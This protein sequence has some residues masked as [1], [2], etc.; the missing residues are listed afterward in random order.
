MK[1]RNFQPT[2]PSVDFPKNDE[3]VLAFWADKR[4]FKRSEET[5][6]GKQPFV[7]YDGPPGTNG[8]PHIGHI[9]QSSLKDV[10]P[11]FKTMQGYYVLRK[12]GWDTHGLPVELTSE[13][14]LGLKG[15]VDIEKFGVGKFIEHCR[16]TVLRFRSDWV[17]AITRLGRFVDFEDDYLTMSNDFIQSDWWVIRQAF[18]KG[19][20]Y[21]DYKI[22]PY[23]SR[24]GTGL[25]SHEVAQGYQDITD[26]TITAKFRLLKKPDT[27]ILAWTTTPWTLLGNVALAIN[28]ELEYCEVATTAQ[29]NERFILAKGTLEKN[30]KALGKDYQ[31]VR[32]FMGSELVG[33][34]YE[35]LWDFSK[36]PSSDTKAHIVIA[37]NY[38]TTDDGTGVVH[39]A[40]YGEDDFRLIKRNG[41]YQNQ[42]VGADGR[43]AARCGSY[44]GR[45][46][47]EEGLDV[48]IVKDLAARGLLFDKYRYE[49][50]YP[51]CW[52]CKSPLMYF[53]KSS[54]FL[55][56]TAIKD[57]MIAANNEINWQPPHTKEGRFGNWLE[58]NVDWAVSR[59]R[60]W[61]S[62]INVWASEK[63]PAKRI[64][65]ASVRELQELGAFFQ[66]SGK[67]IPSD[68]DLHIP[69]IDDVVF[70]GSDGDLYRRESGVLDCWFNAGAMP[71]G[72][73]GYPE[74]AGSKDIFKT[75][76]PADFICEAVDQTR[77]WFYTLLAVSTIVTGKSSFKNVICTDLILD[78]SGRK[79]SKSLGNV[80]A[81]YPL[82]EKFGADAVRWTFYDSNPWQTKRYSEELPKEA[83]RAVFIPIWN[84]YSFFVTYAL[85][86]K[87]TP[88]QRSEKTSTVE[89]DRWIL[90]SLRSAIE[91]V[92]SALEGYDIAT[93]A[94]AISDFI[95]HL[96]NWY[97]RRS[98]KRFW[99]SE[100]DQ[101]KRFAY[102]TLYDVL[103]TFSKL[104]AP[105]APFVAETIYQNL[106]RSFDDSAPESVHL[107]DWPKP[108]AFPREE[109]LEQEIGLIQEAAS[110]AR[111]LRTEHNLK[112]RQPLG[113]LI[114]SPADSAL[115]DAVRRHTESLV[116]EINIKEV[117]VS[118]RSADF[119]TLTIKPNW[120]ALGPRFGEKMK[121]VGAAIQKLSPEEV[122]AIAAG[123]SVTIAL[124]AESVALEPT[125]LLIEQ[126]AKEGMVARAGRGVTVA[127]TTELTKELILEGHAREVL[128]VIQRQRKAEGFEISDHINVSIWGDADLVAACTE[129]KGYLERECLAKSFQVAEGLPSGKETF[130]INGHAAC[131]ELRKIA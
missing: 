8:V 10:W 107:C 118:D 129:H 33:L 78:S 4:V 105:M 123:K 117:V 128:S 122:Q 130:D 58:N 35:P 18:D 74:K 3:S 114:V 94:K 63:D 103:V 13:A 32:T 6:A 112:V 38:V 60:Y 9:M 121:E 39:M 7:F 25:S 19:L 111:A 44:A 84:C 42:H 81:P 99:K 97:I 22:V 108:D 92:T 45:Y 87:W 69:T 96:S 73:F 79:M 77:G 30:A 83:L 29:P 20:L 71:W 70:K 67:P 85:L 104:I 89:L 23:C 124:G 51:H 115:I 48:D 53:A 131:L 110:L 11:R 66:S 40:L 17:K 125:D 43:I 1:E 27:S 86:D 106:V 14:E 116:E 28:A 49:H 61:G 62:P 80:V 41:V 68:I 36:P 2:P 90:G 98:R 126:K 91:Q 88:G 102:T 72:Q 82:I 52:R 47:R 37:D 34:E 65:P 46:F 31:V 21:K 64:C 16:S 54:W 50:A 55:K 100:D 101:D 76:F 24:C 59:D 15:K 57:Q 113:K 120:R 5:R 56:T 95:E 26:L 12:A 75:Q 109:I 93:A 119:V 127:L